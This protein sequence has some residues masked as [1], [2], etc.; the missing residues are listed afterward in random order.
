VLWKLTLIAVVY[1]G[2]YFGFGFVLDGSEDS[3]IEW[4]VAISSPRRAEMLLRGVDYGVI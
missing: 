2:L 4:K 1:L 3:E